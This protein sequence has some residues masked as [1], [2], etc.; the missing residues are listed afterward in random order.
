[1]LL[2][3]D[4]DYPRSGYKFPYAILAIVAIWIVL[5]LSYLT[6]RWRQRSKS[7]YIIPRVFVLCSPRTVQFHYELI[8]RVG[9]PSYEFNTEKH[10]IDITVLGQ[11]RNEVVPMTRLNTRTLQDEPLIT[12]LSIIVYRLVELPNPASLILRHSGPFKAWL[13]VYDFTVIDLSTNREL[14]F[15]LNQYIG[16]LNRMYHLNEPNDFSNVQY[17]IDDVPLPPWNYEDIFL[18]LFTV[19]N[20]IALS[21]SIMPINCNYVDDIIAILLASINGFIIAS[22]LLYVQHYYSKWNQERREYFSQSEPKCCSFDDFLRVLLALVAIGVGTSALYTAYGINRLLDSL[23]WFLA[24]TNT[25]ILVLGSWNVARLFGLSESII[26]LGLRMRGIETVSVGMKYSELVSDMQTKS[27][28]ASDDGIRSALS[29]NSGVNRSF[30]PR[31]SVKSFGFDPITGH[32]SKRVREAHR[33]D[34]RIST[35]GATP[36]N[37]PAPDS[38]RVIAGQVPSHPNQPQVSRTHH[39]TSKTHHPSHHGRAS[40]TTLSHHQPSA[41]PATQHQL[42]VKS[43]SNPPSKSDSSGSGSKKLSSHR[44]HSSSLR[45]DATGHEKST[46]KR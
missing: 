3:D 11:Q 31:S 41:P 6:G 43:Q 33:L 23:V 24:T 4:D 35:S 37:Q 13:Y 21:I 34:S 46:Q 36:N 5:G 39:S 27:G 29:T 17:P 16:S 8:L 32:P 12:S 9:L 45:K 7:L 25:C 18:V 28:S 44:T 20:Y 40:Q 26:G 22:F 38:I 30:G 15:S 42:D 10:D 19:F 14:Y 1:M 2:L